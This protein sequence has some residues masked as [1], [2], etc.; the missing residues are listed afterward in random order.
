MPYRQLEGFT[1]GLHNIISAFPTADYSGLRKRIAKLDLLS[2]LPVDPDDRSITI[3]VDSTGI[4]VHKSGDYIERK[5]G[6]RKKYIKI[7]FSVR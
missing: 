6:K 4:K 3:A 5:Y 2:Y 7:H 1:S